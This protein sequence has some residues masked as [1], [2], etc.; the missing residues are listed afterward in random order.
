[1][2]SAVA[3]DAGVMMEGAGAAAKLFVPD[4]YSAWLFP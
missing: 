3:G 1:M 4:L 2:A